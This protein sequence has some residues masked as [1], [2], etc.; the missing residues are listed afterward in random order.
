MPRSKAKP[1]QTKAPLRRTSMKVLIAVDGSSYTRR[2]LDFLIRNFGVNSEPPEFTVLHAVMKVSAHALAVL[3]RRMLKQYYQDEAAA[4][5]RPVHR[6]FN[7]IGIEA[8]FIY[9]IG[10]PAEV[11][12]STAESGGFDVVIMGAQG[13]NALRRLVVGSVVSR[14]MAECK[15][16]VLLV[17]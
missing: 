3:D 7:K 8:D 13:T 1:I 5:F 15:V 9:R 14:V 4:V 2:M 17:P 6:R 11:I 12:A 10:N 16:P